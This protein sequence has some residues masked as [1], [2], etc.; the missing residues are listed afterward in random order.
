MK[1]A[2]ESIRKRKKKKKT[3][4]QAW[5]CTAVIPALRRPRQKD[6]KFNTTLGNIKKKKKPAR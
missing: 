6:F 2:H 4:Y 5:W 3:R 1:N